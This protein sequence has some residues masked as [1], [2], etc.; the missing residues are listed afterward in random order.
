MKLPRIGRLRYGEK[1]VGGAQP[2]EPIVDE[3]LERMSTDKGAAVQNPEP[4]C[5]D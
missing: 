4:L 1:S 5:A 2:V 3:L